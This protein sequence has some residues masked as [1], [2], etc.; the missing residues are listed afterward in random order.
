MSVCGLVD[1]TWYY[2]QLVKYIMYI[3][4]VTPLLWSFIDFDL[5]NEN[6]ST[7]ILLF[8]DTREGLDIFGLNLYMHAMSH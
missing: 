7:L 2:V 4:M 6:N 1:R 5:K 3:H 8:N